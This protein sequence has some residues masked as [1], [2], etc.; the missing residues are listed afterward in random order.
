[1]GEPPI[2][3]N[4]NERDSAAERVAAM[5]HRVREQ[6]R[7]PLLVRNTFRDTIQPL[8]RDDAHSRKP[9]RVRVEQSVSVSSMTMGVRVRVLSGD[10]GYS[11]S[12]VEY[13]DEDVVQGS[14]AHRRGR[15]GEHFHEERPGVEPNTERAPG[16]KDRDDGRA[17]NFKLAVPVGIFLGGRLAREPPAEERDEVTNEVLEM[18]TYIRFELERGKKE[19]ERTAQTVASVREERG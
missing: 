1:M 7:A 5:V 19:R 13:S 18:V 15:G 3:Q 8:L 6:H 12:D 10:R 11:L 17:E 9:R 4:C 16:E 14:R 2:A